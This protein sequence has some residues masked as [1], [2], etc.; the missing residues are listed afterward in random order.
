MDIKRYRIPVKRL[1]R[2]IDPDSLGFKTT[3]ELENIDQSFGQERAIESLH[4]GVDISQ[5]GYNLYV[6]GSPGTG[7]HSMVRQFL[8][9]RASTEPK[10][11]DWCY[12]NNFDF[13][14]KPKAIRLPNGFGGKFSTAMEHLIEELSTSL[15]AAFESDEYKQHHESIE[16]ALKERQ[17][18]AFD[19]L[20]KAASQQEIKLF[21]TP[22]GFAFAPMEKS[23]VL[24]PDAFEKLPQEKKNQIESNVT[25][26]QKQLQSILQL[27][28]QWRK[29]TRDK[30]KTLNK[31]VTISAVGHMI[32]ELKSEFGQYD[33]VADYLGAVEKDII[34]N[35]TDFLPSEEMRE[36]GDKIDPGNL[37]RYKVN[38]LAFDECGDGAPI[39]YLDNPTYLNLVGRAEHL[40]QY[41]TLVTDFS[42]IKPGALHAANGGYLL[43]DAHK[44]LTQ[45]YAWEG[46]KRALHSKQ[47]TIESLEKMLSLGST[48]SLEPEPIPLDI[49]VLILG[50]REIYYLLHEYDSEFPEL[51]KVQADLSEHI[52]RN[53]TNNQLFSRLL[54]TLIRRDNLLPFD[55][56]AIAAILEYASRLVEDSEKL[57]THMRSIADILHESHFWANK[58]GLKQVTRQEVDRA[59]EHRN[60]RASRVHENVLEAINKGEISINTQGKVVGQINGLS[61]FSLGENSF[62][63]PS[64]ITATTHIG[65]GNLIDIEREVDLGGSI[66]SKGVLILTAFI[67]S[68]YAQKQ[69]LALSASIVFEQNYGMVDGDSASM[70]ELCALL[71]SLA[72]IPIKQS[73]AI[74]GSVDQRGFSQPI[75]GVNEKIEGFF[76]VCKVSGLTGKQG[77]II[78]ESNVRH[79]MLNEELVKAVKDKQFAIY[80]IKDVDEA[81]EILTGLSAGSIDKQGNYPP[82]TLNQLIISRLNEMAKIRH[83]FGE[84]SKEQSD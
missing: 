35:V 70:A 73:I 43:L 13:P 2:H 10:P 72:G 42:L 81:M 63:Q 65:E 67:A 12:V 60:F 27:I 56:S 9:Q 71:S 51:F 62:G 32:E 59:V 26:L 44:L 41:G 34:N 5:D 54:A 25:E 15:P 23:E 83:N 1:V 52:E 7:K 40:S 66:H 29:E 82:K 77:V 36:S 20:T 58:E 79:L 18:L 48:I 80:A 45:P 75:G 74:T 61:V 4:F 8:E 28:P 31:E 19:E 22:S 3:D 46:V 76:Q 47:I 53:D 68:R 14:H 50:D 39:V 49:K 24:D 57:T 11:D 38:N 37:H 30:I 16:G 84:S 69:P 78:P 33:G 64:R 21:R 55:K 6:M 17:E